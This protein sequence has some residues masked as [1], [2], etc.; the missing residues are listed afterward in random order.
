MLSPPILGDG[1][2]Y[3]FFRFRKI[4]RHSASVGS[5]NK[6]RKVAFIVKVAAI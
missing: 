5:N 6:R 3:R 2:R 4:Y 1:Q